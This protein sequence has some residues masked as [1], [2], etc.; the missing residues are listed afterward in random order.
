METAAARHRILPVN[1]E[2][3]VAERSPEANSK[4]RCGR[5]QR[6]ARHRARRPS[7]TVAA[8]IVELVS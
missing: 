4:R 5:I 7:V 3:Q 8:I 2:L 1:L 6:T